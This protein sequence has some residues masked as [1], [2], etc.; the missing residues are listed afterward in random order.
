MP[1]QYL[2]ATK[3]RGGILSLD[4]RTK[5][6]MMVL[7]CIFTLG[8]AGGVAAVRLTPLITLVPLLF[9]LAEAKWGGA[10]LYATLYFVSYLLEI[11][12]LPI[13]T[14]APY[15]MILIFCG[16]VSHFMPSIMM[17]YFLLSTVT[18][19][20]FVAALEKLHI[21]QTITIPLS[22]M[23]RFFPTVFEEMAAINDAM[24]M[25]GIRFGGGKVS[26]MLEYRLIPLLICSVKIG[27]EL[28][29]AS[30]TRGMGTPVKRTN[31]CDI[32]FHFWDY[33]LYA[34]SAGFIVLVILMDGLG[35]SIF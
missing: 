10:L 25:R 13:L 28:S 12:V 2:K 34:V 8:G 6:F 35:V 27:E 33:L 5:L 26:K 21:P 30:L 4:P 29:A 24:R 16:A 31:V 32:G 7:I 18:V 17:G 3:N 20:E 1:T 23:F 15:I 11:Q 19:S 9:L 14:G 22:V